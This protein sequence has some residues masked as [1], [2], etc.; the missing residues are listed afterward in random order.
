MA[1]VAPKK[2]KGAYHRAMVWLGWRRDEDGN[3]VPDEITRAKFTDFQQKFDALSSSQNT[4]KVVLLITRTCRGR[5]LF[6]RAQQ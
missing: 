2:R 1:R 5:S 4:I 3:F 6:Q